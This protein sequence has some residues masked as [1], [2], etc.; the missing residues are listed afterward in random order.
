MLFVI[1]LKVAT[2]P[3]YSFEVNKTLTKQNTIFESV[4][5][6]HETNK[7]IIKGTAIIKQ[8]NKRKA[9]IKECMS[10]QLQTLLAPIAR[11]FKLCIWA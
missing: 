2:L 5:Y 11:N 6:K 4:A 10:L 1:V 3:D 8:G 7:Q 9:K